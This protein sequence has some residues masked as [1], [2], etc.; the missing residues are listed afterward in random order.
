MTLALT[1]IISSLLGDIMIVFQKAICLEVAVL[2][3]F[4][5]NRKKEEKSLY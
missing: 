4:F 3:C 2:F 5:F 1:T